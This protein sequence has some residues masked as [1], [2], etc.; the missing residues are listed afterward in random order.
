M[1]NDTKRIHDLL[2]Q[3]LETEL[4][5]I[6]VYEAAIGCAVHDELRDEWQRY[7]AQTKQHERV[8]RATL[9]TAGLDAEAPTPGRAPVRLIGA[10]LVAAIEAARDGADPA[11]AEVVAA[12]CVVHAETKDHMNWALIGQL[13]ESLDGELG[14]ALKEAYEAGRGPGGRAPVPL[15]RVGTR[16]RPRRTG[17]AGDPA[18]A[19]GA[20]A[21]DHDDRRGP[22]RSRARRDAGSADQRPLTSILRR[23]RPAKRYAGCF[24]FAAGAGVS[25]T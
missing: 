6:L 18:A 23:T 13:G 4:G 2:C 9:A 3:A 12:E 20:H 17:A 25:G 21:R 24:A 1:T 7:L 15:A 16:A 8:L 5:G 19:G 22:C 11:A 10:A 14:A